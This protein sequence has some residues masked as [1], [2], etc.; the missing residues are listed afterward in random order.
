M[1]KLEYETPEVL[2][3]HLQAEGFICQS[4]GQGG[5]EG[6]GD[7]PLFGPA[8]FDDFPFLSSN[9]FKLPF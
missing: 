3:F 7:E 9:P 8:P 6:T 4:T 2:C 1:T 5:S